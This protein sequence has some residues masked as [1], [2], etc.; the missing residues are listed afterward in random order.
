MEVIVS[1]LLKETGDIFLL[2]GIEYAQKIMGNIHINAVA[3]NFPLHFLFG[4][5]DMREDN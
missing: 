2:F 4:R 1:V 5:E 3:K